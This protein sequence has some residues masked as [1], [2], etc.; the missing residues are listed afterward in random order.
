M[1]SVLQIGGNMD[2]DGLIAHLTNLREHG[3]SGTT[4]VT[5][6][7]VDSDRWEEVTGSV[8]DPVALE[9]QLYTDVN[10]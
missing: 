2:I 10:D 1:R 9:L 4:K 7:D 5:A 8:Y 3:A 6:F